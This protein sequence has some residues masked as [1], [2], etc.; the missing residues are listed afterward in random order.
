MPARKSCV[1]ATST[2]R[3]STMSTRSI[4]KIRRSA[5]IGTT[6]AFLLKPDTSDQVADRQTRAEL[7]ELGDADDP[8]RADSAGGRRG[9]ARGA[10]AAASA[11]GLARRT[12][13]A[14]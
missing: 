5:L 14:R 4:T 8:S 9:V 6:M 10:G 12:G 13:R 1:R 3:M 7:L 11:V 2:R